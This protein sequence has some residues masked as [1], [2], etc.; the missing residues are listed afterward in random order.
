MAVPFA[1][2]LSRRPV[3]VLGIALTLLTL[4]W[5]MSSQPFA[6]PDEA[7]HYLR[8]L[9]LAHGTLLGP[10]VRNPALAG[11]PPTP[12]A[13][14]QA[15]S[16]G[17]LTPARLSPP[18]VPCVDGTPDV[19][20]RVCLEATP[21]G[22]Y[23]PLGYVAPAVAIGLSHD[24]GSALWL[25][26]LASAILAVAFIVLALALLWSGTGWSLLGP[27]VA[28]TP[29]VLFVASIINPSSLEIASCLAFAAAVLR[30][31]RAPA[32]QPRWVW[33][34]SVLSGASAILAWQ[35]GPAFVVADLVLLAGLLGR[36][37]L[38][39][40]LAEQRR[41][42]LALAAVL[43]ASV[44]VFMVYSRASGVAHTS[45]G[46]DPIVPSLHA[47]LD[48]LGPV[49]RESV[50]SFGSLTVTLPVWTY[51]AWALLVLLLMGAGLWLGTR[52]ARV[53]LTGTVVFAV[54]FPVLAY[55]WVQR[56]SGFGMQGRYVLPALM[57]VPLLAGE[58]VRARAERGTVPPLAVWAGRTTVVAVALLQGFAWWT[59]AR[60]SAG[61]QSGFW[62][63]AHALWTPP[64]GWLP[65]VLAA[66][67]G[68][69]GLLAPGVGGF[70]GRA[71]EDDAVRL[72]QR[73]AW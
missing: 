51:W 29:M 12:K 28:I 71:R 13:F 38:A 42:V 62:F 4:A 72:A 18:I 35:A 14:A 9:G 11:L 26:R 53:V 65:W 47:G 45:F 2:K 17:V 25:G 67:L 48:Q 56:H 8:A 23:Y 3:V 73:S 30:I 34:A 50:G 15:D 32:G 20:H 69:A 40:L 60:V 43:L 19:G 49:L 52:R 24:V 54:L 36:R 39:R 21:T 46:I 64:L 63:Y 22:D 16:R 41:R 58:T 66:A 57:L 5:A 10:R 6:A 55:G 31:A 44:L 61:V 37:G 27:L 59:N 33:A 7:S 1:P 68:T 70:A